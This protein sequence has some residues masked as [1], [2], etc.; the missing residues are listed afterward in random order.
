MLPLF[1]HLPK[2]P[3]LPAGR[4][5]PKESQAPSVDVVRRV[6]NLFS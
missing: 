3:D 4:G 2:L 5:A 6:R 1:E